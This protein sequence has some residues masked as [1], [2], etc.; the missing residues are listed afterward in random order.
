MRVAAFVVV[1]SSLL[2]RAPMAKRDSE[3]ACFLPQ[4]TGGALERFRDVFDR[5]FV[6]RVL[7]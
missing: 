5:R 2:F 1:S 7:L 6:F 4:R 3:G